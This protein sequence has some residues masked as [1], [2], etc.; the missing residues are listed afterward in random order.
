M[1][2]DHAHF[3]EEP[4]L[5]HE[6]KHIS[7]LIHSKPLHTGARSKVTTNFVIEITC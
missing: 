6:S 1:Y 3:H 7:V 2:V 5:G 4:G